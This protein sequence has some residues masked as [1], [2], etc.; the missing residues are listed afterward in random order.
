MILLPKEIHDKVL[1]IKIE[2]DEYTQTILNIDKKSRSSLFPWKGQFSP[3]LIEHI[4]EENILPGYCIL[5][6]FCGSGTTLYESAK[7]G[8]KCF[9]ADVNPGAY[10]FSS[11]IKFC[12]VEAIEREK[13]ITEVKRIAS[14]NISSLEESN[15]FNLGTIDFH[16]ELLKFYKDCAGS[17]YTC[18]IA[19]ASI[20]LS[21]NDLGTANKKVFFK[22]LDLILKNIKMLP[23]LKG[24]YFT[25][26][27]DA[28][29][30]SDIKENSIDLI[31]TSPPYINVFNYH[32]N[33]RKG[34]EM[35]GWK[36]LKVAVSEIGANRKNRGNRFL[37][38]I[39]YCMD[40]SE[41]FLE[42]RRV[43]SDE[44]KVIIV[45]G[46]ES[47]VRGV[48]FKNAIL[49]AMVCLGSLGFEVK[50][51]QERF[52]LNRYG[53]KIYEDIF[54]LKVSGKVNKDYLEL[55]RSIGVFMLESALNNV[56]G[57]VKKDIE[58][59]IRS[60][61]KVDLSPKL[62]VELPDMWCQSIEYI[63][64]TVIL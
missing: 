34:L 58:N 14:N 22:S 11:I 37:T 27:S 19:T 48:S 59:A 28:R 32:Q 8:V 35:L 64:K 23:F 36:P 52:F 26:L 43:L 49:L 13:I 46:R 24:K 30:L 44:G 55:S 2:R 38:V 16:V 54:T 21:V 9:G 15:L 20:M 12:E 18:L 50:R 63:K 4:L 53:E 3:Q 1:E 45:V 56:Q 10:I 29:Y 39:Q 61:Y 62:K 25:L 51:W 40:M 17:Y 31:I 60:A 5:D 41:A 47:N 6:P 33:Y 7:K 42:M 57:E